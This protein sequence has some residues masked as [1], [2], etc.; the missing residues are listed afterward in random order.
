[1]FSGQRSDEFA[2]LRIS[3]NR[4]EHDSAPIAGDSPQV[5]A[6]DAICLL[7]AQVRQGRTVPTADVCGGITKHKQRRGSRCPHL[8]HSHARAR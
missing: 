7:D 6:S 5:L 1:L 4:W 3:C 2:R 8:L